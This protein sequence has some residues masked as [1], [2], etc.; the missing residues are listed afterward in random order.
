MLISCNKQE[1]IDLFKLTLGEKI[2]HVID[3]EDKVKIG[4]ETMEYPFC[5][6][7][8]AKDSKKYNFDGIELSD[9][10]IYFQIESELLKTDSITK[11]GGGHID[12]IPL[13]DSIDLEKNI[14]KYKAQN[15]IYGL[16][17]NLKTDQIKKEILNKIE[18]RYGKG[19]K[20]PNTDHGLYWNL[21]KENKYIFY[22]PDYDRLIIL[23][24]SKLSKTCYWDI[25]NGLIDFG[26]CD[27]A[28]YT[29]E[30]MVNTTDPK[31]VKNKP[32]FVIDKNWNI[33]NLTIGK[34]TE[35]DFLKSNITKNFERQISID[36]STGDIEDLSYYNEYHNCYMFFDVSN[37]K[38][39]NAKTNILKAY[40]IY[41][42][43]RVEISFGNG[44]I[45]FTKKENILKIIDK[46]QIEN[47]ADL[48]HSNYIEIK[49]SNYIIKLMFNDEENFSSIYTVKKE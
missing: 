44:I 48:N 20:N 25:C 28:A 11:S 35:N 7:I 27:N 10:E 46:N 22:A 1:K 14:K 9:T 8:S 36:G 4:V 23:N 21:K 40:A 12:I 26:G 17:I 43:K 3:F 47:Y 19:Q 33:N 38:N 15:T 6:F 13:K 41:D 18:H 42:F 37:K 39:E 24:N 29:K 5:L 45:P 31:D 16:R 32:H 30:L 34:S 2:E 49:N